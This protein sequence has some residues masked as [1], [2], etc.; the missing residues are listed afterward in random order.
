MKSNELIIYSDL[1]GTML[2]DWERGPYVPKENL[3]AIKRF[4]SEGGLFSIASGR[5]YRDSQALFEGITFPVPMVLVNGAILC[6][7]GSGRVMKKTPLP[8]RVKH[9]C[10]DYRNGRSD[11]WLVAA[12]EHATH[13]VGAEDAPWDHSFK[14][15]TR[16]IMTEREY[17]SRELL[18]ACVVVSDSEDVPDVTAD[19]K[20][21]DSADMFRMTQS[22]PVF[23][24]I[25]EKSVGKASGI[26]EAVRLA[27]AG[28]RKLV[29]IGDYDNDVDMLAMADIAACPSNSLPSVLDMA[30]IVTCSNNE[31]AIA[32]LIQTLGRL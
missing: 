9:E 31:G 2:T 28:G 25:V 4:I 3:N 6:E 19:L 13:L 17:L 24:E 11:L 8:E 12:D 27:N 32:D 26:T 7:S 22:S 18:K 1:D 14:A 21:F 23:L 29:C 15:R 20:A 10:L 16:P 5:H 30:E